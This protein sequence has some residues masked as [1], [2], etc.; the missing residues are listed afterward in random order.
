MQWISVTERLP[1]V[2]ESAIV[3]GKLVGD[4]EFSAHE[5]YLS[6]ADYWSPVR[7]NCKFES[8]TWWQPMPHGPDEAAKK[9]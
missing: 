1:E 2:L 9:H 6:F 8:V 7:D 4:A 3:W 5:A